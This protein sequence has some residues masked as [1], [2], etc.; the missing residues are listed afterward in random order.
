MT[1]SHDTEQNQTELASKPADA[2]LLETI[3]KRLID[4]EDV[5]ELYREIAAAARLVMRSEC[6]TVQVYDAERDELHLLAAVGVHPE[7]A[8]LWKVVS[9]RDSTVCEPAHRSRQRIVVSDV[10]VSDVFENSENRRAYELNGTIAVQSTPLVSRDGRLVGMV[11][12]HWQKVHEPSEG[13]LQLFDVLVRQ[14]TESLEQARHKTSADRVRAEDAQRKS[15]ARLRS[16]NEELEER[17]R[18]RTRELE[19]EVHER[20]AGEERI[21][22]LLRKLVNSEEQQRHRIARELHDT[23]GQQLAALHMNIEVFGSKAEGD[24]RVREDIQRIRDVFDQLNSSLDF[25]AWELR[26]PSLDLLGLDDAI[27]SYVKEWS[28][29]FGVQAVYEGVAVSG[30]RLTPEAE[31]NLY[32]IF[33]EALQNVHKHASADR[34][35]VVFERR[36]GKAVLIIEDNGRGYD[37]ETRNE[38]R[39]MGLINMQERAALIGGSVEIESQLGQGTTVFVRV[40]VSA[41]TQE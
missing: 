34:V 40:P 10:R 17:V 12:T 28:Q 23:V 22:N 9:A 26:P 16:L 38:E 31:T 30:L 1:G 3:C 14:A 18:E 15:E 19:A 37:F 21:K 4:V 32:R 24:P 33:Q 25:L 5:A 6:A 27:A 39:G 35:N 29:Q 41:N 7:S 20:R 2:Q 36:D 8:E 13:E 11:S